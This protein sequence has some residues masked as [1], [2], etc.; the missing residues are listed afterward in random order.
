M[1]KST[2]ESYNLAACFPALISQWH[3]QKNGDA[4]PD[5]FA[6]FSS[7]KVWWRC[8]R[9][10]QWEATIS[11]RTKMNRGCPYCANQRVWEGNC[12]ET[13]NPVSALL[14]H[15]EK[16]GTLTPR[17]VIAWSTRVVWWRCAKG[18][19]WETQVRYV[20]A[21]TGCP[22]CAR[23]KVHED[24][25]L[26]TE[27]PELAAQ[28]HPTRNGKLRPD[29]V[30]TNSQK[31]YWWRCENGHDWQASP[32][33]R[34]R[35]GRGC[36]YCSGYL[37]TK[38]N[39]LWATNRKLSGEWHREKNGSLR[40]RDVAPYSNKKVWWRCREG[41]EWQ[42]TVAHRNLDGT[43]CPYCAHQKLSPEHS[44]L[45]V[46]QHLA[47][48]WHKEK[49]G[50]LSPADIFPHDKRKVWWKCMHGHVW[51]ATPYARHGLKTGCPVC[52]RLRR[53][54]QTT[55]SVTFRRG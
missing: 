11:K 15:P 30:I 42:A 44:L 34:N 22:V 27:N 43:G 46:N 39:C 53:G 48:E 17:D 26:A 20:N 1:R 23:K 2:T 21:K 16:N 8:E 7:K 40:L 29:R 9:G 37:A 31:R 41:H 54:Q 12:L 50:K 55:R 32:C 6:P 13:I 24:N 45:A 28:W 25:C 33:N 5:E 36:P 10:H 35:L 47:Y 18:H 19:E 51:R 52:H 4:R 14:W 3:P 38:E 49:N